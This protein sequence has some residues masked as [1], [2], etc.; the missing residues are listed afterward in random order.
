MSSSTSQLDLLSVQQ[1][2]KD[3]TAN[4]LFNAVSPASLYGRRGLICSGLVWGYYGGVVTLGS[5]SITTIANGTITLAANNTNYIVASAATGAVSSS[6]TTTNWN[7]TSNYYR[8][9]SAVTGS[10]TVTS[11]T[12]VRELGKMTG[13]GGG[14]S[15]DTGVFAKL[16]GRTGGQTLVG[17]SDTTDQL[18]LQ[19]TSGAGASGSVGLKLSVGN[20]GNVDALKIQNDGQAIF[21]NAT[22]FNPLYPYEVHMPGLAVI[23]KK[24]HQPSFG[25]GALYVSSGGFS[26]A[27]TFDGAGSTD[28]P[29]VTISHDSGAS[30][31]V[32]QRDTGGGWDLVRIVRLQDVHG[33]NAG[34][35]MLYIEDTPSNGTADG[36]AILVVI[37]GTWRVQIN[38]R[39]PDG[40]S[41]CAHLFDT[42]N[43]LANSSAR[44]LK[45]ANQGVE[46]F[47]VLAS[48]RLQMAVPDNY[49]DDTAAAAGGIPVGGVYRNGSQLMIRVT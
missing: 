10:S 18:K 41:A 3:V 1:S 39:E 25:Y 16:A 48:G 37:D 46:K 32:E 47:S 34:G 30:L 27:A 8:L 9:Y 44:L 6:T 2:G 20:N 36:V 21:Y 17:G 45:V 19:A 26:S 42:A 31:Q 14:G 15:S 43:S 49:A 33:G 40:P 24:D 28:Y 12:D 23:G 4:D 35:H 7:D 13:G 11:Y 38:P 22:Q 5:G 29:A